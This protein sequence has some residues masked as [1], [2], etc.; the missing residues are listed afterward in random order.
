MKQAKRKNNLIIIVTAS[1]LAVFVIAIVAIVLVTN[2]K[3][4]A[5]SSSQS[6]NNS[7]SQSQPFVSPQD[8]FQINFPENFD[9]ATQQGTTNGNGGRSTEYFWNDGDS[10]SASYMVTVLVGYTLPDSNQTD[11]QSQLGTDLNQFA[12]VFQST[13]QTSNFTTIDGQPAIFGQMSNSTDGTE[14]LE[15]FYANDRKF[16][17]YTF[18]NVSLSAFDAFANSFKLTN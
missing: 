7:T 4:K 10:S 3:P 15:V 8:S 18:N 12:Q 6:T 16:I 5:T 9:V 14:Y 11:I 2:H 13:I 17:L 1:F